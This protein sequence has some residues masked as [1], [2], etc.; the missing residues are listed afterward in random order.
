MSISYENL[1]KLLS[2]KGMN[3]TELC[4]KAGISTNVLAK[5]G[6]N[7][8]VHIDALSKICGVLECSFDEIVSNTGENA[9]ISPLP[10]IDF[11]F[12]GDWETSE[13][14]E[15]VGIK[16]LKDFPKPHTVSN[17]KKT[18]TKYIRECKLSIGAVDIF[19]AELKKHN[20]LIHIDGK[21][22]PEYKYVPKT[23]SNKDEESDAYKIEYRQAKN[24]LSWFLNTNYKW[25]EVQ[26]IEKAPSNIETTNTTT[27]DNE[28]ASLDRDIVTYNDELIEFDEKSAFPFN[29]LATIVGIN[30]GFYFRYQYDLICNR[31]NEILSTLTPIEEAIIRFIYQGNTSPESIFKQSADAVIKQV[32]YDSYI[33]RPIRKLRHPSRSKR[34]IHTICNENDRSVKADDLY[35]KWTE[36]YFNNR[37]IKELIDGDFILGAYV[38]KIT[39]LNTKL[40]LIESISGKMK[41]WNLFSADDFGNLI[42]VDIKPQNNKFIGDLFDKIKKENRNLNRNPYSKELSI[43][44]MDLSDRSFV[45]LKSA[46]IDTLDDV[47]CKTEDDLMRVKNLGRKSLNEVLDKLKEYGY[48]LTEEGVFEYQGTVLSF[49]KFY[50]EAYSKTDYKNERVLKEDFFDRCESLGFSLTGADWFIDMVSNTSE[51]LNDPKFIEKIDNVALLGSIILKKWRHITHWTSGSLLSTE[52]RVWFIV[53]FNHLYQLS[54]EGHNDKQNPVNR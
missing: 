30:Q 32:F 35:W 34:I 13:E 40:I 37:K 21:I 17:I 43:E 11:A 12:I 42:K 26:L 1:W 50:R 7:E 3:K 48:H 46:S 4:A 9:V 14:F 18:L 44:E 6:K 24:Y 47:I 22:S 52:N 45:C 16:S 36:D 27:F 15:S 25:T 33:E 19:L 31:I 38:S 2:E 49:A 8:S 5:L 39:S 23:F 29:L 10:Q 53:A 54:I 41:E 20:I 28:R 51:S